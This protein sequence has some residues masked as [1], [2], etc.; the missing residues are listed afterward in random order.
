MKFNALMLT[1][2]ALTPASALLPPPPALLSP[3][4]LAGAGT[5]AGALSVA[6]RAGTPTAAKGTDAKKGGA[7]LGPGPCAGAQ[8]C[9]LPTAVLAAQSHAK[10]TVTTAGA[11][12]LWGMLVSL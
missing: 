5:A 1:A 10:P 11:R 6:A 4:G 8:R 7:V 12:P 3:S 9:Y 2:L